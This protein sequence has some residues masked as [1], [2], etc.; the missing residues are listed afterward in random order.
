MMMDAG[1]G[2]GRTGSSLK[3]RS[4]G[5]RGPWLLSL[6]VL[7]CDRGEAPPAPASAP[8]STAASLA[9]PAPGSQDTE[10]SERS[11]VEPVYPA[12][13]V[14]P[15]PRAQK[16]CAAIYEQ[17]A[18]HRATCCGRPPPMVHQAAAECTR[19]LSFSLGQGAVVL[20]DGAAEACAAALVAEAPACNALGRLPARPPEACERVLTGK[21]AAGEACRSNLECEG[22]LH[23]QNAGPTQAGICA[24]PR[25][26]GAPCA[27]AADV[28]ATYTGQAGAEARHP[29]CDGYCATHRCTPLVPVGQACRTNL[30]C[31]PGRACVAEKCA[32]AP[33]DLAEG[34]AC[35]GLGCAAGLRCVA[36]ACRKPAAAGAACANDFECEGACL[37]KDL[38]DKSGVC[39]AFCQ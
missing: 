32:P 29:E 14:P 2:F 28:L 30:Q 18:R 4:S 20:D 1:P 24:G 13:P 11:E 39:G 33:K 8:A 19:L 27:T 7:A 5:R 25:P 22:S 34:A 16:L 17:P 26:M 36:G 12:G 31:G 6:L 9:P 3:G 37:K 35:P 10:A 21:R 23:C 38:L 15:D